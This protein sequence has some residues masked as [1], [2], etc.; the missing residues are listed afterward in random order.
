MK[1]NHFLKVFSIIGHCIEF[2]IAFYTFVEN[3]IESKSVVSC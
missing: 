1:K 3:C 2:S